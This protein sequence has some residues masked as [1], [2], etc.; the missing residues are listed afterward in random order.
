ML[1]SLKAPAPVSESGLNV[2]LMCISWCQQNEEI[3]CASGEI[4]LKLSQM[5][6][7]MCCYSQTSP[8]AKHWGL[9]SYFWV[10]IPKIPK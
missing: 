6:V 4:Q 9:N 5:A 10:H 3:L 2:V 7:E 1:L 8:K